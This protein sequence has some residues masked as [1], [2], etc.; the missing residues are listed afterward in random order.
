MF[1][2]HKKLK[3]SVTIFLILVLVLSSAAYFIINGRLS[4]LN[5]KTIDKS[6][7]AIG[8]DEKTYTKDSELDKNFINI[9]LLGVDTRDES[10]EKGRSDSNIILTIDK[11]HKKIKMTSILRDTIMTMTGHGTMEGLNQ[12]RMGHA[13][14]YG[15]APLAIKTVNENFNLNIKNY[16]KVDFFGLIKIIDYMG[17]VDLKISDA[18]IK[19][20]NGYVKEMSSLLKVKPDYFTKSGTQHLN[21][22][23]AVAYSRIRYVGNGDYGRTDRQRE[24]LNLLFKKVSRKSLLELPS[25]GDNILPNI[26]TSLSKNEIM[27]IAVYVL[28]NGIRSTSQLRLPTAQKSIYVNNTYFVAIDKTSD[29][30][31]LHDFIFEGEDK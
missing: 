20:A 14:A 23:Q 28:K 30:E 31:K 9:L 3:I 15:G 19:V 10:K 1:K 22:I 21:G 8:I 5:Y 25:I 13:Y 6:A 2:K 16:V 27:D 29:T 17:G 26:E 24:V 7:K 4:K 12:D 11:K 18:E